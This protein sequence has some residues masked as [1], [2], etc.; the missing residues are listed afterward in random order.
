MEMFAEAFGTFVTAPQS[1]YVAAKKV[2]PKLFEA[3]E[4]VARDYGI[5]RLVKEVM[6]KNVQ[7]PRA[8]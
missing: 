5:E 2:V 1:A 7:P 6:P 8:P 4:Q 3:V